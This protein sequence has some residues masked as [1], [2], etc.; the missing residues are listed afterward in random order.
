MFLAKIADNPYK[1]AP[2]SPSTVDSPIV[3]GDDYEVIWHHQD[4]LNPA[5]NHELFE[6]T[7]RTT[8]IDSA[9]VDNGDWTLSQFSLSTMRKKSGTKSWY[10][11]S[12]NSTNHYLRAIMPYEVRTNDT[13]SFWIWYDIEPDYDYFYA[14]VS[15][16]GGKIF[17]N[18][19]GNFTTNSNPN[20]TNQG[21]GITGSSN[22]WFKAKY[23][24]AGYTGQT[25]FVRLN[26][27]TDPG[28]LGGGVYLDEIASVDRYGSVISVG[29]S[30]DTTRSF[31]N[32]PPNSY[33]YY[34]ISSDAEGQTS[35][36][37][38]MVQAT[39]APQ[40]I[41]GDVNYSGT[42]NVVDLTYLVA[43]LFQG[44][45]APNPLESGD[46]NCN[47]SINIVDLTFLVQYLFGG[48]PAPSC[49]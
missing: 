22:G 9:E 40:Y 48:G 10:S 35:T 2:P 13:L 46:C 16:D 26:Y 12:M 11:G 36:Y 44:G 15:T 32:K 6:L 21:N 27:V 19:P 3:A 5:V 33:Y 24:L 41:V 4:T 49:P 25:V 42:I 43:Y 45:E 7:S 1:L 23:S 34:V 37:S 38:N 29:S 39:V 47:S 30:P 20:G 18:L 14:Q 28:V 8:V 31:V 17:V